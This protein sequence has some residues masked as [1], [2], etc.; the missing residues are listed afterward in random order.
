MYFPEQT[1]ELPD[2]M[3][4]VIQ[5]F[6]STSVLLSI[7]SRVWTFTFKICPRS[8]NNPTYPENPSDSAVILNKITNVTVQTVFI[9]SQKWVLH[10]NFSPESAGITKQQPLQPES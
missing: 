3:L 4:L 2:K 8:K 10:Y 7:N 1:F 6:F 5:Y 9:V